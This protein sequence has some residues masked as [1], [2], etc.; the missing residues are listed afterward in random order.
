[1]SDRSVEDEFISEARK[2]SASMQAAMRRYAQAS[3]WLERRRARREI[4]LV[5]RQE[6]REQLAARGRHRGYTETAVD[7]YRAHA[8]AV[9]QRA[10]DPTVDHERRYR[11]AQALARHR[12][13]MAERVLRNPH[14][15]QVE[16]GIALDGL[17]AATAFPEFKT[18]GR[19]FNRA[20]KVKG[21]EA[22]RY[23]AQVAREM[24]TAGIERP[25][26]FTAPVQQRPP[27]LAS[28][29]LPFGD[30]GRNS[31]PT[32]EPFTPTRVQA[33]G[34]VE[35]SARFRAVVG[36]TDRN[37]VTASRSKS[38]G[39]EQAATA[40]MRSNPDMMLTFGVAAHVQTWDTRD[41]RAPIYS[42]SGEHRAV[43]AS[44]AA[45]ETVLRDRTLAGQ[46]HRE[47]FK[48]QASA[49][50]QDQHRQQLDTDEL[51]RTAVTYLP[52][53]ANQVV[54][55]TAV[56]PSEAEAA[57]WTCQQLDT[58]RPAPGTTIEIAAY[59][60]DDERDAPVFR[61][62]GARGVLGQEVAQWQAGI[63]IRN[64]AAS[65]VK[66]QQTSSI[67]DAD[68]DSELAAL[69]DRHRL[70]IQYNNQLVGRNA[71]LVKNLTALTSERDTLAQ[72]LDEVRSERKAVVETAA[73]RG[74]EVYALSQ[75]LESV[76]GERDKLR[77]ERDAAVRKLAERTPTEQRY[78]SPER[79]AEQVRQRNGQESNSGRPEPEHRY[80]AQ[81]ARWDELDLAER[82]GI[83]PEQLPE[84]Q[85]RMYASFDSKDQMYEWMRDR[86]ASI[87]AGD[88]KIQTFVIDHQAEVGYM[89]PFGVEAS[90]EGALTAL[91]NWRDTGF[92]HW[93]DR[94]MAHV[95]DTEQES[96]DRATSS[97]DASTS[98]TMAAESATEAAPRSPLADYQPGHAL[99]D[100]VARNGH[101]RDGM[102]R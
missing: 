25:A 42:H 44:L 27:V 4:S 33:D 67:A 23:R 37:G 93:R 82:N 58:M 89:G 29:E 79:Q 40:W 90:R 41:D 14:L 73:S 53:N 11:D 2:F 63:E 47:D 97:A 65:T 24:R 20:N 19:L 77:F 13:D 55:E 74:R 45:R 6:A 3:N 15:T 30:P 80:Q 95:H 59:Q 86:V 10:N 49:V 7:R 92:A 12:N 76:T 52:E 78:G 21:I 17:D 87:D 9:N 72:Q 28:M 91:D 8:L 34:A 51:F 98:Q 64:T 100:A 66:P 69:K 31:R 96:A 83:K 102:E 94:G 1:M 57:K 22:L 26:M 84:S 75:E 101:D 35:D 50:D 85:R 5:T 88:S 99:A 36:W 48:L 61:A 32:A 46:V 62:E 81:V 71:E 16:Q 70:S 18:D 56:H 54:Y 38:F 39:T 68:R 43:W 60:G